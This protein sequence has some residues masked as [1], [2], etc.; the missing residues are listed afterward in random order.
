MKIITCIKAA[1]LE[2]VAKEFDNQ[3]I[4]NDFKSLK[5]LSLKDKSENVFNTNAPYVVHF[6]R[7]F[8]KV[9]Y[10]MLIQI[11]W[12]I[13]SNIVISINISFYITTFCH[14]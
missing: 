14:H 13:I 7:L 6:E 4:W 10:D 5:R 3:I 9:V 12:N 8:A 2:N 11:D 1:F